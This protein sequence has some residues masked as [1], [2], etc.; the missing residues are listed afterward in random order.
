MNPIPETSMLTYVVGV[1]AALV[2]LV[3]L[4]TMAKMY[5]KVGPN[6]ALIVYGFGG[7]DIITG[8]GRIVL[9][10]IQS[11]QQLSLELMSF[12]VAPRQDL[13]TVQGVA[14]TVEAVAQIKVKSD[15]ES[16]KTA[17]EQF[18]DKE[19]VERETLIRLVM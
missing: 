5:R 1:G 17:A 18:L 6:E 13:Y 4:W 11:A 12:D 14:V 8:G 16:I 19:P 15:P 10:L 3:V 7:T 2:L 9:P